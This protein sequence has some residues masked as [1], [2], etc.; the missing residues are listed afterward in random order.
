MKYRTLGKT[1]LKIS[2]LGMGTWQL[3]NDPGSWVGSDLAESLRALHRYVEAGGNFIDTAWGYGYSDEN[4]ERH[5]SEELIGKFFKESGRRNEIV[6]ATK[7]APKNWHWPALKSDKITD[8]FPEGH[9]EKQVDDSLRSL[10]VESIDLVQFH[11]WRDEWSDETGWKESIKKI[12]EAGKVKNWGISINDYQP[13]NCLRTLDTGLI[14]TIQ[15]IFNIFHQKPTEKLLPYAKENNIGLIA[16]VPMDEGG[17]SG[18]FTKETVFPEGD[19]RKGYFGGERLSELVERTE[20]LKALL[21]EDV[22]T[23]PGLALRY[24]M[25]FDALSTVIP[26]MRKVEHVYS[27]ASAVEKGKL[28][29]ALLEEIKK[30]SWERNFYAE[31]TNDPSMKEQGYV[32]V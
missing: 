3:A 23:L 19:F 5:P 31:E 14:S 8:C 6:I 26:G 20:K 27:N 7:V 21:G 25:S 29:P 4:P 10:G 12:T 18:K 30:H 15:F 22:E 24:I 2:E 28:S 13:S 1:N 16:R 11:V 17:L 9:I 32:E